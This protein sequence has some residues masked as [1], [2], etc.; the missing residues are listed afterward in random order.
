MAAG[1]KRGYPVLCNAGLTLTCITFTAGPSGWIA[2]SSY[3]PPLMLSGEIRMHIRGKKA[4]RWITG[5]LL[6][7][8]LCLSV[9]GDAQTVWE[10][11]GKE[12]YNYLSR[13]AQK[14]L[15]VFNDNIR[16]L[17]RKYIADCLDSLSI[18]AADLSA[19]EKKELSFYSR[20]Y[21]SEMDT[22]FVA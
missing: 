15:I 6:A 11:H 18:R 14:G 22:A 5:L 16:P 20:E 9:Q 4:G 12:V 2:R 13:M 21:G 10:Y 8:S 1:A 3:K 7:F 17:S 19:T